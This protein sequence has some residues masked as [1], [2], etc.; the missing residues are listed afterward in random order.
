M[1]GTA[2]RIENS[3]MSVDIDRFAKWIES[4]MDEYTLDTFGYSYCIMKQDKSANHNKNSLD[5]SV[6]WV[7]RARAKGIALKG[8]E[9]SA[10]P[11]PML[12]TE[13]HRLELSSVSKTITAMAVLRRIKEINSTIDPLVTIDTKISKFLPAEWHPH[14]SDHA[15]QLTI[16][17]LLKHESGLEEVGVANPPPPPS[18]IYDE[19]HSGTNVFPGS[20]YANIRHSLETSPRVAPPLPFLYKNVNFSIFRIM[21]PYMIYY[22]VPGPTLDDTLNDSRKWAKINGEVVEEKDAPSAFKYFLGTVYV[23]YVQQA[24]FSVPGFSD[25]DVG[26]VEPSVR[27]YSVNFPVI[28]G[29]AGRP[30]PILLCGGTE[31]KLT[32]KEICE[33]MAVLTRGL[34][35]SDIWNIM[36]STLIGLSVPPEKGMLGDYFGKSGSYTDFAGITGSV[37][38]WIVIP[39]FEASASGGATVVATLITNCYRSEPAIANPCTILR[40][41]HDAALLEDLGDIFV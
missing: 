18:G 17:H 11:E 2:E 1:T 9:N 33:L 5:F 25:A 39:P 34:L 31:W 14:L 41:A 13:E 15:K 29:S 37:S 24:I 35:F 10:H 19:K 21:L 22:K 32:A 30:E 23:Q 27:Y 8:N 12:L 4:I 6:K 40:L 38:G 16:A 26:V 28:P 7:S 20:L 36:K 3:A